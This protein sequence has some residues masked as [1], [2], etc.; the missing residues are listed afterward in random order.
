MSINSNALTGIKIR[1]IEYQVTLRPT[2]LPDG[3][4]TLDCYFAD[5][6]H[7][8]DKYNIIDVIR[9]NNIA[10]WQSLQTNTRISDNVRQFGGSTEKRLIRWAQLERLF[11]EGPDKNKLMRPTRKKIRQLY[12]SLS[13]QINRLSMEFPTAF[14][15]LNRQSTALKWAT[16]S[17][18]YISPEALWV[19]I[20]YGQL[21]R[22]YSENLDSRLDQVLEYRDPVL[23]NIHT[24]EICGKHCEGRILE[25][26]DWTMAKHYEGGVSAIYRELLFI[27]SSTEDDVL[28]LWHPDRRNGLAPDYSSLYI[29]LNKAGLGAFYCL[30]GERINLPFHI[31]QE[32]NVLFKDYIHGL[33][34]CF[35]KGGKLAEVAN[36]KPPDLRDEL[37]YIEKWPIAQNRKE[38]QENLTLYRT[39]NGV[40]PKRKEMN[41][42]MN[43]DIEIFDSMSS[44]MG[45]WAINP[46]KLAFAR[47]DIQ[48]L[49]SIDKSF[50]TNKFMML[51]EDDISPI[52]GINWSLCGDYTWAPPTP[53]DEAVIITLKDFEFDKPKP[54][55]PKNTP[56]ERKR[57][58]NY[59]TEEDNQLMRRGEAG[60]RAM[61][62]NNKINGVYTSAKASRDY[63]KKNLKDN[64][65]YKAGFLNKCGFSPN[66][67]KSGLDIGLIEKPKMG[68]YIFH[69]IES[70]E[71]EEWYALQTKYEEEKKAN[72]EAFTRTL[73]GLEA[74]EYRKVNQ[75][76]FQNQEIRK[77]SS[78]VKEAGKRGE[79]LEEA[80]IKAEKALAK[81]KRQNTITNVETENLESVK[82]RTVNR[83]KKTVNLTPI[84]VLRKKQAEQGLTPE[85]EK[86]LRLME[87]AEKREQEKLEKQTKR[88]KRR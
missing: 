63:F 1:N 40:N 6:T 5:P 60:I 85:E 86:K 82:T 26:T 9:L 88:G 59:A 78:I 76:P 83:K 28:K 66:N 37:K 7:P 13:N 50:E 81:S 23:P 14:Q 54:I 41:I 56:A 77:I 8:N 71:F 32:I 51:L 44:G 61:M 29:L 2:S 55:R 12:E 27:L 34:Q 69:F 75:T 48:E 20:N 10:S 19:L 22:P 11:T 21:S 52:T 15:E 53:K 16:Q 38:C 72:P 57:E 49:D 65:E 46:N 84:T 80:K 35:S 70:A 58:I 18:D 24:I 47:D 64:V 68:V 36:V 73:S 74:T 42:N 79:S 4:E 30:D 45:H 43:T 87:L 33:L 67:L 39:I 62:K 25:G 17:Q 31:G 3:T